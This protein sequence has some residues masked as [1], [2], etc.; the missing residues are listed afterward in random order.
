MH[1]QQIR[2]TSTYPPEWRAA[3]AKEMGVIDQR[4]ATEQQSLA[5]F[6]DFRADAEVIHLHAVGQQN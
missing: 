3:R 4:I 6:A 5:F 2:K 1:H